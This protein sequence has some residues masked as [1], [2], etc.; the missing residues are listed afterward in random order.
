M[1]RK[2]NS[3]KSPR[4]HRLKRWLFV[5]AAVVLVPILALVTY[6]MSRDAWHMLDEEKLGYDALSVRI[7]DGDDE[8]FS[9]L[10][11]GEERLLTRIGD[12]PEQVKNA[13]IAAEDA[14][15]YDHPGVD[16]VRI[17]GAAWS[18]LKAG[19]FVEGASTITQQLIKLTHL[20]SRKE[21]SRKVDEAILAVQLERVYGFVTVR[22]TP[23]E[24][25]IRYLLYREDAEGY[26]TLLAAF[27]G[28]DAALYTD[29][30]SGLSGTV[31]YYVI[32]VH[33]QITVEG[34]PLAG[35]ASK[36]ASLF[37]YAPDSFLKSPEN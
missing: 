33:P 25:Y 17:L 35:P 28:A 31:S 12:L 18:D 30:V 19:A 7:L 22:F 37:L 20:S 15:F 14:R 26:A 6:V 23:R 32:G 34:A 36:K 3:S 16:A 13:F 4:P 24:S 9:A 10:G 29:D 2:R 27:E 21:L 8:L 11:A 5:W 1:G